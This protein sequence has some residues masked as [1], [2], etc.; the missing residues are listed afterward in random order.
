MDLKDPFPAY[1]AESNIEA[2]LVQQFLEQRGVDAYAVEE[3]ALMG[4]LQYGFP[5]KPQVWVSRDD[6]TR[7]TQYLIEYEQIK[8]EREARRRELE[9]QTIDAVCEKCGETSTYAGSLNGTTQLCTHCGAYVDVGEFDWPYGDDFG[10]PEG[11]A[12]ADE[13]LQA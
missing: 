5:S 9:S 10:E 1:D 11:E 4:S 13:D 3:G 6:E 7:V 12:S 2:M 8:A